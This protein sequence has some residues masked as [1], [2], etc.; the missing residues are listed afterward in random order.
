MKKLKIGIVG[1]GSNESKETRADVEQR[2][3]HNAVV[4]GADVVVKPE[5]AIVVT[6]ILEVI[7]ESARTGKTV[8]FE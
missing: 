3:F 1:C 5:Q 2:V 6:R 4:N 7:Y 8:Y